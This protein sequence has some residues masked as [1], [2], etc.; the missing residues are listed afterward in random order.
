MTRGTGIKFVSVGTYKVVRA[1]Q[2][3]KFKFKYSIMFIEL[4]YL[5]WLRVQI[6]RYKLSK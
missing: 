5:D 4:K 2:I 1:I 3:L 6:K